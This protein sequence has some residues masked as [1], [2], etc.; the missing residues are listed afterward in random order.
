MGFVRGGVP[1]ENMMSLSWERLRTPR[2]SRFR[3]RRRAAIS[4]GDLLP[5]AV[6]DF[7]R[8]TAVAAIEVRAGENTG[9]FTF[10]VQPKEN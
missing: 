1:G 9:P 10:V 4:H 5:Q 8:T 2:R 3:G 6:T 7:Q